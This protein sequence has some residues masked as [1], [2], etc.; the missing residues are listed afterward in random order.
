MTG[1][2]V[3]L[4][5]DQ[6]QNAKECECMRANRNDEMLDKIISRRASAGALPA[7]VQT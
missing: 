7:N 2:F 4:S 5:R 3:N 1:P 6:V